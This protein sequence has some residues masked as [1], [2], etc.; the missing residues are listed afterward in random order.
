MEM[1]SVLA[2]KA[3]ARQ[4]EVLPSSKPWSNPEA[5]LVRKWFRRATI[6]RTVLFPKGTLS[7][8]R[9]STLLTDIPKTRKM[10]SLRQERLASALHLARALTKV[11]SES[12]HP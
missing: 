11:K 8:V 4:P 1:K 6:V 9:A 7:R 2:K 10:Q 12:I 3:V 5:T